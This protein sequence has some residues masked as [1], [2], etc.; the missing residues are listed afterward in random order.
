MNADGKKISNQEWDNS[1]VP[2]ARIVKMK[3][4]LTSAIL[5]YFTPHRNEG[6]IPFTR[7][8]L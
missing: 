3:D 7:S 4:G 6:S 1:H 8:T 5:H 2:D